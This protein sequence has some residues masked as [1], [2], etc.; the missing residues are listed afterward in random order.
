MKNFT[1]TV[2]SWYDFLRDLKVSTKEVGDSEKSLPTIVKVEQVYYGENLDALLNN[3]AHIAQLKKKL[4]LAQSKLT[5]QERSIVIFLKDLAVPAATETLCLVSG[6]GLNLS[7]NVW[8]DED[9]SFGYRF[10]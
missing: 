8:Y 2:Q 5:E 7:V 3:K 9:G 6:N 10:N 1:Q 4:E